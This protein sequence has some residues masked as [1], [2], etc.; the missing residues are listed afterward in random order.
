MIFVT[1]AGCETM[2]L[3]GNSSCS[4]PKSA[5]LFF[6]VLPVSVYGFLFEPNNL[7]LWNILSKIGRVIGE[8]ATTIAVPISET[9]QMDVCVAAWVKS[10]KALV[11]MPDIRK[12]PI[13]IVL[14][15][16]VKAA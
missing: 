11:N 5:F 12:A 8:L 16:F 6:G 10:A 4:L 2:F 15:E 1:V 13:L 3:S 7:M 14:W 9:D